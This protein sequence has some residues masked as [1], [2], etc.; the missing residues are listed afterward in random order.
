MKEEIKKLLEHATGICKPKVADVVV[1]KR[2]PQSYKFKADGETPNNSQVPLVVYRSPVR[3]DS[4]YDPAAVFEV[5]FEKHGWS[6]GWRSQMYGYNHFHTNTHEC[7]G[8]AKGKLLA[9]FGGKKGRQIELRAG[10]VVVIPAGVGH[11][12]LRQS[13]DLLIVGVY[14]A[15]GGDY[16]EPKPDEIAIDEALRCIKA[17]PLPRTDPVY[18]RK[19]PLFSKWRRKSAN[20]GGGITPPHSPK[21]R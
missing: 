3:L 9:L 1:R 14:P 12:H 4:K 13:K 20:V 19:G 10:D 16:N 17:V 21:A 2:K 5:L 7:L 15:N 6:D 8:I 18:G 11:K